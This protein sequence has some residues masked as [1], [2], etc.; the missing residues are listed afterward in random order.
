[1]LKQLVLAGMVIILASSCKK[2]CQQQNYGDV[3][4]QNKASRTLQIKINNAIP[5]GCLGES[6]GNLA[7]GTSCV[8][9][10]TANLEQDVSVMTDSGT[11]Y[12]AFQVS[13][14]PCGN[15]VIEIQ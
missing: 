2:E 9:Q 1:M 13:V 6:N 15:R 4:F 3:T 5:T 7:S 11:V 8:A 14:G 12:W 10:I